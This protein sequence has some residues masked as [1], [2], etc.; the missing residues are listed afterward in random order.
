MAFK[1]KPHRIKFSQESKTL[2]EL[3]NEKLNKFD[4]SNK[5]IDLKRRKI[6]FLKRKLSETSENDNI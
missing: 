3:H 2:D 4:E 1:Y 6:L 5:N